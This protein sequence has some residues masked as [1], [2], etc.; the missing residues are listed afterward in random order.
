MA[1]QIQVLWSHVRQDFLAIL[2]TGC[3]S[4]WGELD[5]E[6]GASMDVRCQLAQG[7]QQLAN[8]VATRLVQNDQRNNTQ[9]GMIMD[10]CTALQNVGK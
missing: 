3:G 10:I 9:E 6:L 4:L 7:M 2:N 8:D 5:T 1:E